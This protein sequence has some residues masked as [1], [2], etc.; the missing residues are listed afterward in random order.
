MWQSYSS[1]T[2]YGGRVYKWQQAL[3]ASF[4][5]SNYY[6]GKVR[7]SK[8]VY[9]Y[10]S[11]KLTS[12]EEKYRDT[13][14]VITA[15]TSILRESFNK[16]ANHN[17]EF[18]VEYGDYPEFEKDFLNRKY[19]ADH[20]E[21]GAS[22]SIIVL[23]GPPGTGKSTWVRHATYKQIVKDGVIDGIYMEISS[24]DVTSKWGGVPLMIAKEVMGLVKTRNI[25]SVVFFDEADSILAK[26]SE[27]TGGYS[28]QKY[29]VIGYLKSELGE[30]L[31]GSY[32]VEI[33]MATNYKDTL[34]NIEKALMDRITGWIKVDPPPLDVKRR[35]IA[36]RLVKRITKWTMVS[37]E[38]LEEYFGNLRGGVPFKRPA[39]G[40]LQ[41][42]VRPVLLWDADTIAGLM[43]AF[44]VNPMTRELFIPTRE[45]L[46]DPEKV[47]LV[48]SD[49]LIV[50]TELLRLI[51]KNNHN[52]DRSWLRTWG[53]AAS[54]IDQAFKAVYVPI[55]EAIDRLKPY[56]R[57]Q[58]KLLQYFETT[59]RLDEFIPVKSSFYNLPINPFIMLVEMFTRIT[60]KVAKRTIITILDV[61]NMFASGI[62]SSVY[63]IVASRISTVGRSTPE[64]MASYMHV[65]DKY[66]ELVSKALREGGVRLLEPVRIALGGDWE[67]GIERAQSLPFPFSKLITMSVLAVKYALPAIK[68]EGI[69]GKAVTLYETFCCRE[70]EVTESFRRDLEEY[71]LV[72]LAGSL[73]VPSVY[74]VEH[75]NGV[76]KTVAPV[77]FNTDYVIRYDSRKKM[78]YYPEF[79]SQSPLAN[80]IRQRAL[81]R[82]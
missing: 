22:P 17:P 34:V 81:V 62:R 32:P 18:F 15:V 24:A 57:Y 56:T 36:R 26:P 16:L 21:L 70:E 71:G 29:E 20:P 54:G 59:T 66:N 23:Y 25:M 1:T 51:Y 28:M 31:S 35:I 8:R 79:S 10:L 46:S 53:V 50:A 75:S 78:P 19:D 2:Q 64:R 55:S 44:G 74:F 6:F 42:P 12:I 52:I 11:Y 9:E 73:R 67:K 38:E 14:D 82:L 45:A 30:V 33:V 60:S 58:E 77:S 80:A 5:G 7:V 65:R 27:I 41:M 72:E 61:A 3:E 76:I 68:A 43:V 40:L 49:F 39:K 47:A 48:Y 37:G 63:P 13:D 4:R 69:E